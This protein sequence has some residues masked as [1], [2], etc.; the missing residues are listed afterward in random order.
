MSLKQKSIIRD[1]VSHYILIK[2]LIHQVGV[3][4]LNAYVLKVD[5]GG[6][7]WNVL[8]GSVRVHQKDK[9]RGQGEKHARERKCKAPKSREVRK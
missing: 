8:K 3:T 1:K 9:G 7:V 5:L 6:I 4:T 2:V